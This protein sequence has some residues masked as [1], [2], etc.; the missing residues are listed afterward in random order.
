MNDDQLR[1]FAR[2]G[3]QQRLDEILVEVA[4]IYDVFPDLPKTMFAPNGKVAAAPRAAK[5]AARRKRS[6]MTAAQR[7][8]VSARMKRYWAGQRR[9]KAKH[10]S[11]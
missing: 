7:K 6:T 2:V 1:Q 3:A 4:A 5:G 9:E 10:A 8:A 11:K